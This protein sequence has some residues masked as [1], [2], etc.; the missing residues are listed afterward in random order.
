MGA[1]AI[2]T[3][4]SPPR[5]LA[6]AAAAA[7]TRAG[8]L[9][10]DEPGGPLVAVCGLTG[11]AGTTTVALELA[12]HAARHGRAPVLLVEADSRQAGL[13]IPAG[14]ATPHSLP[15]LAQLVADEIPP[16][17]PFVELA[18]RLRLVAAT[19]RHRYGADAQAVRELLGDARAAHGLVVVDCATT[20]SG[21]DPILAAATHALWTLPAT[22]AGLARARAVLDSPATPAV[23]R[24]LEVLVATAPRAGAPGVRVRTLRR[25][26]K[27]RCERLI[28]IPHSE[29][30][31]RGEPDPETFARP[32]RGLA[33]TLRRRP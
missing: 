22:P 6:L 9:A 8:E 2:A 14:H 30:A 4:L 23:G 19:P 26:A 11:G 18:P 32:L 28:L 25:L 21:E 33:P 1:A 31:E 3:A 13:A 27:R 17:E 10:L 5:A 7:R 29:R 16:D 12:R 20:W 15:E 24:S